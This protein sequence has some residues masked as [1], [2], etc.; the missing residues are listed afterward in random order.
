LNTA[1]KGDGDITS[2]VRWFATQFS[3]ACKKSEQLIDQA[4]SVKVR[5]CPAHS[6]PRETLC[7]SDSVTL[8]AQ[9]F[10]PE[11]N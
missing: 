9:F 10:L 11:E 1:L 4:N 3:E 5:R 6:P 8:A 2:W 7:S